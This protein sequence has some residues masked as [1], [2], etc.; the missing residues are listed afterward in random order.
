MTSPTSGSGTGATHTGGGTIP[1][2]GTTPLA[3]N[4]ISDK[5]FYS[6]S[7]W[8]SDLTLDR[9]K[10]NWNEWNRRLKIIVDQRGFGTYL[11]GT[12]VCPDAALYPRSASSWQINNLALRGFILEHISDED[13]DSVESSADAHDVYET[14]RKA[15][16][17]QGLHAQVHVIK[18]IL[19]I[20]FTP[21]TIPYSRTLSKL[22]KLHDKF[23]KMGKMDETKLQIIWTLNALNECQTLQSSINDLLENSSTTYADVK[24][25]ILRE[26]ETAIRRG[27]YTPNSDNTALLTVSNRNNRPICANCK[28]ANHRTEFCISTGGAMAGKSI[29]EARAAQEAAR[30]AQRTTTGGTNKTRGTRANTSSQSGTIIQANTAQAIPPPSTN[31]NKMLING[32]YYIP[33]PSNVNTPPA[34]NSAHAAIVMAPYDEEEYIAV[35][36]T[37]DTHASVNWTSHTRHPTATT[38]AAYSVGRTSITHS[39]LPF[40]LDTGATCHISP[41][42]SDFKSLRTIKQHPVKGLGGSAVYAI[43]IGDID[44]RIASGH[45]LKLTDVLY[46]PESSVRLISILT[47]NQSGNYTTHFNSDGCWVTNKSN[48]TLIRGS[49]SPSKRLYVLSTKTPFVQHKRVPNSPTALYTK[50]PDIE[51]WHRRLGH[52]N[53]QAIIDMAKNGVSKGMPIDLSSLPPKCDSCAL[54]KQSRS[55]VP[56]KREGVKADR[57]L[58]KVYVDLCGPMAVTSRSG[59]LYSM[60]V[61]DDFSG[62]GWSIP[63]RA[64]ADASSSLQTWHKAVT[65]QS[66]E[67]LQVL[68]SDN[69]ELVSKET[70][71]WCAKEGIEHQLTAPYTSAQNGRAERLHRTIQGKA[72][73]MRIDCNAPGS[74]WDEFFATAAYLTNLTGANANTGHTPYER[75]F[76]QKPSLSHLREIGCRAFA[77]NHPTPSKI[78]PRSSPCVLIGYAP[79]SN[80]YRLWDPISS[81]VF[82]LIT[83]P[84]SRVLMRRLLPYTPVPFSAQTKLPRLLLGKPL[85]RR[86]PHPLQNPFLSHHFPTLLPLFTQT[87]IFSLRLLLP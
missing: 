35:L 67:T 49:L 15:H 8:P 83:F 78:Y 77:L 16:Q 36:A 76:G 62:Y 68:V 64:K 87:P 19:D 25:R 41:E 34:D 57:R 1:T 73:T 21:S 74:L 54:G 46:I 22:E 23:T 4:F 3:D 56:K 42:A 72:R 65:V 50:V 82:I 52:C 39:D 9:L 10:G 5:T 28:R 18:E 43:G 12:L 33:A 30:A 61:I 75:W 81:R 63:L 26:E 7:S 13:F 40:I 32:V 53:P 48:T 11:N 59:N 79:H 51:T 55:P 58:G 38:T 69:G 14:L 84:S 6:D 45:T 70:S 27:Q 86:L 29:E 20:R 31:D 37:T 24:R 85:D 71:N 80:A 2:S 44:L 60:N 47:L 17:H 66:G